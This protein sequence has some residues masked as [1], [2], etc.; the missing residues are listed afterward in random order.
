MLYVYLNYPNSRITMHRKADCKQIS[1]MKKEDQRMILIN[2]E[3]KSLE[4]SKFVNCQYKFASKKSL[5]DMWLEID[6]DDPQSEE[7]FVM[8]LKDLLSNHY[9]PFKNLKLNEHC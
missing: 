2:I 4:V 7:N 3:N 1:K 8:Q 5:N 9:K 6:L